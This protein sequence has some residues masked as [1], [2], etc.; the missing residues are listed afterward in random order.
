MGPQPLQIA[1]NKIAEKKIGFTN[2]TGNDAIVMADANMLELVLRNLVSNALKYS[3]VKG[4]ITV[5]AVN[6]GDKV[7]IS[8]TDNGIGMSAE[9]MKRF[10]SAVMEQAETTLGTAKE[11]G[12][13]LGLLLCKTFSR[14]M[15][16]NISVGPNP[17]GQGCRFELI[18]PKA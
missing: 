18:L 3:S 15:H 12:T 7:I 1:K 11:K 14:L 6:A 9:K 4:E 5:A 10:N 16:G 17:S 8:V 13:G 2:Q